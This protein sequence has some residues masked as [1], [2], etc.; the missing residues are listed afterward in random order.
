MTLKSGQQGR[1]CWILK[2]QDNQEMRNDGKSQITNTRLLSL[3][4][5]YASG[6]QMKFETAMASAL[7]KMMR[8]AVSPHGLNHIRRVSHG[9]GFIEGLIDHLAPLVHVLL[10]VEVGSGGFWGLL[11]KICSRIHL[12]K[13]AGLMPI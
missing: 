9:D 13:L 4:I 6:F 12:H 3:A 7:S 10:E 1:A 5:G 8:S 2:T 11:S